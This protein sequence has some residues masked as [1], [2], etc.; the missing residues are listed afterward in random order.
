MLPS[1]QIGDVLL[2][3]DQIALQE[4]EEATWTEITIV[5]EGEAEA[6]KSISLSQIGQQIAQLYRQGRIKIKE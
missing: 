6:G 4:G 5:P 3:R 1:F 2:V